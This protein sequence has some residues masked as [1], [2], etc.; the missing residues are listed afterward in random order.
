MLLV[1]DHLYFVNILVQF[2]KFV[3]FKLAI[4]PREIIK[5]TVN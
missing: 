2:V 5:V 3:G 1:K 4:V